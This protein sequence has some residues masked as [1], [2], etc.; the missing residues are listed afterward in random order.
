M[1]QE[2]IQLHE[3]GLNQS[4]MVNGISI[5][6]DDIGESTVPIVFIHGFRLIEQCGNLK[7]LSLKIKTV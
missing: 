2:I 3:A 5:S 6:Y 1:K 7:F 4:V